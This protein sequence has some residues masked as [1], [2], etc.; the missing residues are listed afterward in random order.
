MKINKRLAGWL[1]FLTFFLLSSSASA[2]AT[3]AEGHDIV[4]AA[5]KFVLQLSFILLA[6]KVG[7]EICERFLKQPAVLGE[8][9]SGVIIGPFALGGLLN[10]PYFGAIFPVP[11]SLSGVPVSTELY[12]FAQLAAVILLF[13]SGLET[14]LRQFLRYGLKA[15]IIALGGVITP[16]VLGAWGTVVFGLAKSFMDPV[17]LFVGATMTATSV[18]IT[19]RVLSDI[20][21]LD[22]PEGVTILAGAVVDDVLGILVLA[23]VVSLSKVSAIGG[24]VSTAA[25]VKIG[26]KAVLFW[27]GV[28]GL[29]ILFAEKIE[30]IFRKFTT[31]GSLV[32]LGLFLCFLIS[33]IA[34]AFGLAMIIGAYSIGLALSETKMAKD[35]EH[36]MTPIYQ[37]MVPVFFCVMGMLVNVEAMGG[38]L[39]FGI[40][41]TILAIISKI[42][43]CGLPAL[44]VGF[45]LRGA[46]RIGIGML[47]RG[48]VALIVA[49]VGLANQ[50]ISQEIFGVSILMTLVTTLLAPIFLVKLFASGQSGLKAKT[51]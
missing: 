27:L 24:E 40:V 26:L 8:L 13:M 51:E 32:M 30:K 20:K 47:P 33:A 4:H 6:A 3:A 31:S 39:L 42:F 50:V 44:T 37:F 5:A 9:V 16:F 10:L 21:K 19:A 2:S 36:T 22:T 12:A 11:D 7:G 23:I 14:D 15:T 25:I 29:G 45:N 41:L 34:E 43:G 49:G 28:T 46:S 17:A 18:G 38:T 1:L 48:E 35:L